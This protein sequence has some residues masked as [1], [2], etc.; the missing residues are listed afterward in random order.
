MFG[1]EDQNIQQADIS[2][3]KIN[4]NPFGG[5]GLKA[6]LIVALGIGFWVIIFAVAKHDPKPKAAEQKPAAPKMEA[7][8]RFTGTQF[9]IHNEN[10]FDWHK[11]ELSLNQEG[12][13]GDAY[14]LK[15]DA[16]PSNKTYMV[17]AMQFAKPD[18]T[19]FNPFLLK[20][21]SMNISCKEGFYT[22]GWK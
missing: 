9:V 12:V 18:G 4:P 21:Q 6:V 1:D 20:P 10:K 13:F 22:G 11:C 16:L 14:E 7:D 19:R 15:V 17:G 3:P 8:V 5:C 2:A